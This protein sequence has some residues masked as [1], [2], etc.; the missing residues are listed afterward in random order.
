MLL[1]KLYVHDI[2]VKIQNRLACLLTFVPKI[3][4]GIMQTNE[5]IGANA[6][7]LV[8]NVITRALSAVTC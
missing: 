4:C 6:S 8:L 5:C 2:P 3:L 7:G 1:C